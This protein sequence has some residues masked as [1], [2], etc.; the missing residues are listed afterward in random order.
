MRTQPFPDLPSELGDDQSGF[1]I[2]EI[3]VTL[4]VVSLLSGL[5]VGSMPH[6]TRMNTV[7]QSIA[8][9]NELETALDYVSGLIRNSRD[10][11]LLSQQETKVSMVGSASSIRFVT[12]ARTGSQQRVLREVELTSSNFDGALTFVERHRARRASDAK[13]EGEFAV[14]ADLRS[15]EF[16]YLATSENATFVWDDHW[17][18]AH[19]PYAIE[20]ELNY[21]RNGR[22]Y[23]DKR[24]VVLAP[25]L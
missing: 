1:T 13:Q 6:L 20:I 8:A 16:R 25:G 22:D 19:R 11:P 18:G 15:L 3:M 4:C 10:L 14:V 12:L 24:R 17:T 2:I 5:I 23:S 9:E 21:V 7:T